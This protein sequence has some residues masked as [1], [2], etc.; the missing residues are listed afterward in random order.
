MQYDDVTTNP[1]CY[2]SELFSCAT[3]FKMVSSLYIGR[4]S[5]EFDEIW[6]TDVNFGCK[7][8]HLTKYQNIA[9]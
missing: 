6:C 3:I 2:F 8:G 9:I 4:K 5:S 7:N 1:I